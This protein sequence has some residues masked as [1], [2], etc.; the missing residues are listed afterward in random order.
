M[1]RVVVRSLFDY[2]ISNNLLNKSQHGF[3]PGKSTATNLLET[4]TDWAYDLD[5]GNPNTA[6]YFDFRKAFDSVSHS[7]LIS[8]LKQYG[9]TGNLLNLISDFLSER[10]QV[11]KVGCQFSDKVKITSGVVQGS[12][13]GPLLFVV[14]IN[15]LPTAIKPPTKSEIYADDDKIYEKTTSLYQELHLQGNINIVETWSIVSDMSLSS[16]KCYVFCICP[17]NSTY[18]PPAYF[19]NISK[20]ELKD[21]VIDL[22]V[23]VSILM[24]LSRKLQ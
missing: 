22:G 20:L 5:N 16:D 3:R 2:L 10:T 21:S 17:R 12:C 6:V 9:I 13:L 8:K 7:K 15:D 4:I 11:T 14:F 18:S 19:L 23:I 1:E 24:I